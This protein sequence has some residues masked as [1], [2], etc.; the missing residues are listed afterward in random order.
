MKKTLATSLLTLMFAGGGAHAQDEGTLAKI[1]ELGE[2][3]V[4]HRD[5]AV[6]FSYYDDKQQ[7]I[8]YAM[9]LCAQVVNAV[10]VKLNKPDLKITY[11]PVTGTT[12][13]PLLANGTI[14][15]ECGTTTNNAERQKQV[16]FSTT[17]FVAGVRILSKKSQPIDT[18]AEAK[19]K[20]VVTLAGTTSVKV[21]NTA[22]T[23]QN[24]GLTVLTAKDLAE[25]M[26]TLETGRAAALIFD[27][28]SIAG[29]AATSKTPDAFVLSGQAL[30]V[31]PYG[32]MLRRNDEA[33]KT[34]VDQTLQGLY[35]SGEINGLYAKWFT[36][37]IPPRGINMNF[38]MSSQLKNVIAHPTDD[39]NPDLYR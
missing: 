6:P 5:G 26:L 25:G 1:A 13:I 14:D 33:F 18:L 29:A 34:L 2:I 3:T 21:I 9:D 15:M 35:K 36:Q 31:E 20:T 27:D 38:P 23:E 28:V 17:N 32:I 4:G 19:G 12:R 8:G 7:P 16:T 10:K 24:L 30:S 37:A 11:M 22:N 39:P